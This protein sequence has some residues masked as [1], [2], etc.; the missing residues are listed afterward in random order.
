MC[1]GSSDKV[2]CSVG[3]YS[4]GRYPVQ[5]TP[6]DVTDDYT[7]M[8][9]DNGGLSG[10]SMCQQ[11]SAGQYTQEVVYRRSW[12]SYPDDWVCKFCDPGYECFRG[13]DKSICPRKNSSNLPQL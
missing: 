3:K 7:D 12:T 13:A 8:Y 5:H 4:V 1:G 10:P 11:C 9:E 6:L 2:A